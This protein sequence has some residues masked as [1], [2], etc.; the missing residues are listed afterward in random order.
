MLVFIDE[1]GIHKKIDHSTLALVYLETAKSENIE[2]GVISLE[3]QLGIATF[4]WAD[5]GSKR[6]WE[7]RRKFIEGVSKLDFTF[8]V[9]IL[10]NPVYLPEVFTAVLSRLMTEKNITKVTIDGKQPKWFERRIK[11]SLRSRGISLKKLRM[12]N[13]AS[14]PGLRLADALA[15]LIRS[16]YDSPSSLTEKL[17]KLVGNKKTA[18]TGGQEIR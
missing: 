1:S 11:G 17:Y 12:L 4:H 14:S 13:D 15:G 16:H 5:F 9:A 18:L 7:I 2:Q 6:G 8:K 3:K 10:K